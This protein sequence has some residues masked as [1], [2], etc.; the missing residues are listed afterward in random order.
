MGLTNMFFF[1]FFFIFYLLTKPCRQHQTWP[2]RPELAPPAA[3]S[4]P[5]RPL[6]RAWPR[7]TWPRLAAPDMAA[8][9]RECLAPSGHERLVAFG[10]HLAAQCF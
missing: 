4:P 9:G 3:S 5:R 10:H 6:G 8:P 1:S 2:R 7:Q